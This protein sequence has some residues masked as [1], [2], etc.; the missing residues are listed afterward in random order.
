MSN[1]SHGIR[2][3]QNRIY[4]TRSPASVY[5][6]A[7]R[8]SCGRRQKT[9]RASKAPSRR[10]YTQ[11]LSKLGDNAWLY[12]LTVGSHA[13]RCLLPADMHYLSTLFETATGCFCG[14]TPEIIKWRRANRGCLS[15][16]PL[17]SHISSLY[18]LPVPLTPLTTPP[19]TDDLCCLQPRRRN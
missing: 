4:V 13:L 14:R 11:V 2:T 17:S 15:S 19:H 5:T 7:L 8:P 9:H 12:S 3:P 6:G 1:V 16:N 18:Y 10:D